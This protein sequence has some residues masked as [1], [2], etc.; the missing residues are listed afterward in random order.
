MLHNAGL[1]CNQKRNYQSYAEAIHAGHLKQS[2]I[3]NGRMLAMDVSDI[4]YDKF[5]ING[6]TESQLSQ[7]K[8]GDKVRLRISNAG[9]SS[10]FG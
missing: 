2:S 6:K 10:Y 4:Y 3:T 9:A 7:F 5:L 1:V 8:A